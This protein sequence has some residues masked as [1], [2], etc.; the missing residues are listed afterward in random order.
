MFNCRQLLEVQSAGRR[1]NGCLQNDHYSKIHNAG[2][3]VARAGVRDI[4]FKSRSLPHNPG[5]I[6]CMPDMTVPTLK[7]LSVA[8]YN[9]NDTYILF[10]LQIL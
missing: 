8:M 6:T 2:D 10:C 7:M 9:L 5:G 3:C 1:K 4:G